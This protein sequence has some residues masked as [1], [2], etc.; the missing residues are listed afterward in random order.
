MGIRRRSG[1]GAAE[2]TVQRRTGCPVAY[3]SLAKRS[4]TKGFLE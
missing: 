1:V 2:L 3:V 4:K